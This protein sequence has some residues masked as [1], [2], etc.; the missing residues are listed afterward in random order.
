M[1]ELRTATITDHY[2]VD[3]ERSGDVYCTEYSNG[4]KVY[5]NYGDTDYTIED[6]K[7]V[8]SNDILLDK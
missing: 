8:A 6:G 1:S 7:V 4:S 5:V 2:C 3:E